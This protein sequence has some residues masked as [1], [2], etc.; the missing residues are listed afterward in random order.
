MRT[1]AEVDDEVGKKDGVRQAVE[2]D[3]MR[4]E[5]VVEER[6]CYWKHDEICQQ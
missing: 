5:V 2:D 1:S 3:P 6:Y 4:T